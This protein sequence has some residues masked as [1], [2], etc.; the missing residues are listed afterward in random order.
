MCENPEIHI[1]TSAEYADFAKYAEYLPIAFS[2]KDQKS[3]ISD[4]ESSIITRTCL[5]N[6]VL[7]CF[8]FS[9]HALN[10]VPLF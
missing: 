5:G 3:K 7:L 6:L 10:F 4:A 9:Y 8:P 2:S 1:H